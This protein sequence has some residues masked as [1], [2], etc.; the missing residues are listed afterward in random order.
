[1]TS[2]RSLDPNIAEVAALIGDPGRAAM[3]L[4]L[5]DGR[6]LAASEL[7]SVAGMTPQAAT[8][9]FK[10][11]VAAGLLVGRSAGRHRFFRIASAEVGHAIETLATIAR[12]AKIVAL[13]QSSAFERLRAARSCYDH[14]AG[15]LGVAVTDR[16][17]ER[18]A[19]ALTGNDFTLAARGREVFGELGIDLDDVQ[20]ERR[21]FARACMDWTERRPHLAGSL[22]ASV[23]A[24]FM[25]KRWVTRSSSDRAL[26]I[27]PDGAREL[28]R[29]F[30]LAW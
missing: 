19:I 18:K 3:L 20:A 16:L 13:G 11:L 10:K 27:T 6:D 9:H 30:G 29:R 22:G 26:R 1:M 15:R 2:R 7:A 23:L 21:R 14:L 17:I 25:R 8:A 5:L 4:A 12:P 24:A 28:R